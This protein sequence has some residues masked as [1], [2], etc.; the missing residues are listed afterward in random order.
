MTCKE[1]KIGNTPWPETQRLRLCERDMAD[2][3]ACGGGDKCIP[4]LCPDAQ[5]LGGVFN[6]MCGYGYATLCRRMVTDDCYGCQ[7][8]HPSQRNH[9]CLYMDEEDMKEYRQRSLACMEFKKLYEDFTESMDRLGLKPEMPGEDVLRQIF[10]K[11]YKEQEHTI[12]Q[13][14][15]EDQGADGVEEE[16]SD[17]ESRHTRTHIRETVFRMMEM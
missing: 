4:I 5:T 7:V 6:D 9:P 2:N 17:S 16:N 12:L 8:N 1:T 15:D 14:G 11:W 10:E 3:M 13:G